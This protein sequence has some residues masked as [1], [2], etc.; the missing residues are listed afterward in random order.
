MTKILIVDDEK[1]LREMVN[2][3]LHK[4]GYETEMAENGSDFLEK[5]DIF[6]PDVV[7]L[8]IMMPG[9]TITEIFEKL[10]EKESNPKIILLTS[11]RYSNKEKERLCQMW[12]VVD[13]I[14]KPFEVDDLLKR[15]H[16]QVTKV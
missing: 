1:D 15:I 11:I 4:E 3:L 13:Y 14:I 16:K 2:L 10:K 8:D 7:T 12:N 6:N 5:L 9:L